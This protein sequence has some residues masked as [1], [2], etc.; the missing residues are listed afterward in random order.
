MPASCTYVSDVPILL[1]ISLLYS[2]DSFSSARRAAKVWFAVTC[3]T[4]LAHV[5]AVNRPTGRAD[6]RAYH[7]DAATSYH[8]GRFHRFGSVMKASACQHRGQRLHPEV[9]CAP[10]SC[11]M[12]FALHLRACLCLVAARV[13]TTARWGGRSLQHLACRA[14]GMAGRW[15]A[16]RWIG[17]FR[18]DCVQQHSLL[19]R[20]THHDATAKIKSALGE[21]RPGKVA[22]N[23][24]C[25]RM[26]PPNQTSADRLR[27][28]S[29]KEQNFQASARACVPLHLQLD[30]K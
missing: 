11:A 12:A 16:G 25:L 20:V 14:A 19:H 27:S 10:S 1:C 15:T 22:L 8:E 29:E 6:A 5:A 24:W 23:R 28:P 13:G 4:V 3:H 18:A 7:R 21:L 30:R 2:S 26:Q 9:L 17:E